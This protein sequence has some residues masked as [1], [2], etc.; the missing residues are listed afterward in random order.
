M[1]AAAVGGG[2]FLPRPSGDERFPGSAL[3]DAHARWWKE[4]YTEGADPE[5]AGEIIP[6][7]LSELAPQRR[8][9]DIGCGEGQIAGR[10]LGA[11]AGRA[12]RRRH[13][14]VVAAAARQRAHDAGGGPSRYLQA[15][16]EELP[17]ADDSFDGI[18]CCLAIEHAADGDALLDEVCR[19]LAPGGRFLLLVNHP[20]YQGPDSGFVDDQILGERYWRVGPYLREGVTVEEV[21]AG[22]EIP[23]YHRPLSRYLNPLASH[24]V[25]LT[26]MHEPPPLPEF[27]AGSIDP[28][29]E[30]AI[31]RLLAMRFELRGPP[32]ATRSSTA[33]GDCRRWSAWLNTSSLPVSPAPDARPRRRRSRTSGGS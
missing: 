21:D 13:R 8:I 15:A 24:D 9:L 14:P 23:F 32:I 20:I 30:A 1:T 33:A 19:V 26:A 6:L 29:L 22:I 27:L 31:P 12:A 4:T 5:Y 2:R 16:G 17:F 25:L 11:R 18:C 10:L 7:V 28:D 3:W